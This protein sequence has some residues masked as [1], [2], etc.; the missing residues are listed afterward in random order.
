MD[1]VNDAIARALR[2]A[3]R[4]SKERPQPWF[5]RVLAREVADHH[6]K[7]GRHKKQRLQRPDA[8]GAPSAQLTQAVPPLSLGATLGERRG[9]SA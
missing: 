3:R 4:P 8:A 5:D 7:R 1:K 6:R 2:A 9:S